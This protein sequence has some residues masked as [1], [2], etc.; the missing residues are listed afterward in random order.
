MTDINPYNKLTYPTIWDEHSDIGRLNAM[1]DNVTAKKFLNPSLFVATVRVI[2]NFNG[3]TLPHLEIEGDTG[4]DVRDGFAIQSA[5]DVVSATNPTTT[6]P[7]SE[8]E[9]LFKITDADGPDD[10]W[11]DQLYLYMIVERDDEIGVWEAYAQV[12]DKEE[13]DVLSNLEDYVSDKEYP[14]MD[15]T[16]ISGETPYLRQVRH[17]RDDDGIN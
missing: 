14:D 6:A 3:I 15:D 16:D 10:D 8:A 7:P 11:D 1:L 13:L 9:Y 2:L 4:P 12:V 5:P 17:T